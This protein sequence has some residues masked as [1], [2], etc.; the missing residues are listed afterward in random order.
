MSVN[1]RAILCYGIEL[2]HEKE[3]AYIE[4]VGEERWEEIFEDFF[5]IADGYGMECS[6]VLGIA[7]ACANEGETY[8]VGKLSSLSGVT[9]S[10]WYDDYRAV[11]VEL[12]EFETQ[13]QFFLI[14]QVS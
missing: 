1:Y 9:H 5:I 13:P 7:I 4:R 11:M 14:C 3:L 6:G 8:P 12:Q 10:S 2:T